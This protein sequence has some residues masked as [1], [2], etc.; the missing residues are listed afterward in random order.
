MAPVRRGLHAVSVKYRKSV[1]QLSGGKHRNNTYD[2]SANRDSLYMYGEMDFN[3]I[4]S[5]QVSRDNV[6]LQSVLKSGTFADIYMATIRS[7]N[8][9]VVAKTLKNGYSKQDEL[10]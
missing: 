9:T 2:N 8:T 3:D 5:W 6:V 1:A 4:Q 7:S 10:F